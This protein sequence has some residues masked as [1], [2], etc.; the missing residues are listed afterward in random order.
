M[1]EQVFL[2]M[3][4]VWS[5]PNA[6]TQCIVRGE[7]R[8]KGREKCICLNFSHLAIKYDFYF[9]ADRLRYFGIYKKI[10]EFLL[11]ESYFK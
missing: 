7:R 10:F 8:P 1:V 2:P 4:E 6:D 3:G 11:R 5:M 9:I